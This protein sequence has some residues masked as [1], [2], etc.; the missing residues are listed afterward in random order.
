MFGMKY[1]VNKNK[2]TYF[3]AIKIINRC[4]YHLKKQENC[5]YSKLTTNQQ[6]TSNDGG[7]LG[8]RQKSLFV[9]NL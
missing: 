3:T 6:T 2:L 4:L 8:A 5:E 7:L 9:A 1:E